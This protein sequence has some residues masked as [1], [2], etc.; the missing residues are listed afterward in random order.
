[1]STQSFVKSLHTCPG[2]NT[3]ISTGDENWVCAYDHEINKKSS[4]WKTLS[5]QES[6]KPT[7]G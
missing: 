1:M 7:T 2:Y 5:H 6:Q 4:Q 3:Q